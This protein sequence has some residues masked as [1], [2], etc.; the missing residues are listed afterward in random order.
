MCLGLY[1]R[2]NDNC[3]SG[4]LITTVFMPQTISTDIDFDLHRGGAAIAIEFSLVHCRG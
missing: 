2:S 1:K 3:A 4:V